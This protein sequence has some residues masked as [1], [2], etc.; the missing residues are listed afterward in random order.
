MGLLLVCSA[1]LL[2][3]CGKA[4]SE[5]PA[6]KPPA[7]PTTMTPPVVMA[8]PPVPVAAAKIPT[9]PT[10]KTRP[11][12]TKKPT[13]TAPFVCPDKIE[14]AQLTALSA[15]PQGRRC[16]RHRLVINKKFTKAIKT[17]TDLRLS[18]IYGD[19]PL[20]LSGKRYE[21]NSKKQRH[22][23]TQAPRVRARFDPGDRINPFGRRDDLGFTTDDV[24]LIRKFYA[25][26]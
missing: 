1:F 3:S 6:E 26:R 10:P 14:N 20:Y 13:V 21:Y 11:V 25:F 16:L 4:K 2:A 7:A 24:R 12:V 9:P 23:R 8:A 5:K 18:H 17:L 22:Y 19:H 15:T